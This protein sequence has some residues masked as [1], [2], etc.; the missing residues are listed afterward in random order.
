MIAFGVAIGSEDK[1]RRYAR[2]GIRLA[3]EPGAEVLT[4]RG[5]RSIFSAYNKLLDAAAGIG[6]L[7]AL[8]IVHDDVEIHNPHFCTV[9]RRALQDP[10]VA[11]VGA[12]GT[13]G[14][15]GMDWWQADE[16]L[17]AVVWDVV[18]TDLAF[19]AEVDRVAP[20]GPGGTGEV[21]SVDGLILCFSRRAVRELRFDEA[22]LGPGFHGYDSD[23]CLQARERGMKVVVA[24]LGVTHY[25]A[26]PFN[27][28][29]HGRWL[30]AHVRF[31]R[32]WEGRLGVERAADR[33]TM[34]RLAELSDRGG[35]SER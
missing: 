29:Y 12:A 7:E 22:R 28:E 19:G 11:I 17:G 14:V 9:L 25:N 18:D 13:R 30:E 23:I 15:R 31:H 21:D 8:A 10:D 5:E 1:F 35:S 20:V 4:V 24:G 16:A 2:K 6:R 27:A 26:F 32:K 33:Q 34:R 3:A